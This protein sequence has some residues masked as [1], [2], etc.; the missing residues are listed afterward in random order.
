MCYEL[1]IL[2]LLL[3]ETDG[4]SDVFEEFVGETFWSVVLLG[5]I[6][7]ERTFF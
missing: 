7:K 6:D 3:S 5:N 4:S 2:F 1:S